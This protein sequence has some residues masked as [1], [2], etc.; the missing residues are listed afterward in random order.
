[1]RLLLLM[2][3]L[4]LSLLATTHSA[5]V[6]EHLESGGYSYIKVQEAQKTYW[7]AMTQRS[8]KEGENIHFNEQGWMQNFH[9]KTL[10]RTFD[11][12]LF[13]SDVSTPSTEK[14]VTQAPDVMK[15]KYQQ[16]GTISIAELFANRAQYTGKKVRVRAEVTKT[17]SGIMKRNWV[18][19][20]DGSR[21]KGQDDMV[22]T[23]QTKT[24]NKGDVVI[25]EGTVTID[26]DFGYGYFYSVIV[27][28]SHFI[29][30]K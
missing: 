10:K 14:K 17:S 25:A 16:K 19:L 11:S 3:T 12:I 30:A 8:V 21:F 6:I 15:S 2:L 28:E 27:E 9:S 1:M 29:N 20:Q 5:K 13:A 24:P 22:F 26:K 18:H 7:I 23:T 4:S